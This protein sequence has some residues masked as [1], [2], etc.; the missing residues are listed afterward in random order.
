MLEKGGR[1]LDLGCAPGSW[2]QYS[3]NVVGPS[4][5]ILGYD[6][7]LPSVR[8]GP[9]VHCHVAD[10]FTL[11]PARISRDA[12]RAL[13]GEDD[14]WE[15]EPPKPPPDEPDAPLFL[16]DAVLSDMA[17][18]T[19]GIRD[20]DQAR[21]INLVEM[22]FGYASVLLAPG[23]SFV[24]KVFQGRGF[25]ALLNDIKRKMTGVHMLRPEATREGSRE[26]FIVA[27]ARPKT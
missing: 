8:P 21:V 6:L 1:V 11:T 7:V 16:F 22:A 3:A 18:K 20:S 5:L 13:S 9:Q 27:R 12:R 23:G 19:T 15:A 2:L 26:S 17:P 25:D 4:G 10:V 14:G 24:A